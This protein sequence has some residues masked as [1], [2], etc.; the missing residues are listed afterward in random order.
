MTFLIFFLYLSF[1]R[2]FADT[3]TE[4]LSCPSVG[5]STVEE[6]FIYAKPWEQLV[7]CFKEAVEGHRGVDEQIGVVQEQISTSN[8]TWTRGSLGLG[9][10]PPV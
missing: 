4:H 10:C 1:L 6:H 5:W 3:D 9:L 7:G 2:Y 8:L